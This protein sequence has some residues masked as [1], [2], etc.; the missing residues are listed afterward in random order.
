MNIHRTPYHG[1]NVEYYSEDPI[2]SGF[3]GSAVVQGAQS[4][5]CLVNIKHVGFNSQEANRSGVNEFLNEQ[6]ARELELRNLQQAFTAKG[7]SS[8]SEA[9][10][11][12]FRYAAEGA[13]GTMTAYNRIGATASSANYGVQYAILREE[14]GFKGYSVTDFTGLN[15]IAAPKES[16]FAGTTAFCGFGSSTSYWTEAALSGDADLLK[17]MQ[18]S[19]HYALYA[20]SRSYAMDLVNTHTV[21]LMT[22]WRAMYISLITISSVLTAASAAAYVVLNIRDKKSV[23]EA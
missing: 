8:K 10:G 12:T 7:R 15:P 6:A 23:K 16:I 1:R 18:N 4:K 9:E 17:A 14:W 5:G 2:L 22:W 21:S 3:T 20:L 11:T 13:R 19:M